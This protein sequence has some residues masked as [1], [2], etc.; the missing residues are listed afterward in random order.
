MMNNIWADIKNYESI[1][2]INKNGEIKSL[3]REFIDK[4]NRK[5]VIKEKILKPCKNT[6]GYLYVPLSKNGKVKN[7]NIHRLL[8]EHFISNPKNKPHINHIDGNKLNNS[9]DNLE[10]CTHKENAE[11]ASKL[12]L[13]KPSYSM[14]NKFGKDNPHSIKILQFDKEGTFIASF[15][16]ANEAKR[17]TGIDNSEILKVCKLK[18]K[19]AGGFIWKFANE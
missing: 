17:V 6:P 7:H 2:Q 12:K 14:K 8:A 5:Q 13:Y 11:H 3:A 18:R 4:T 15:Y 19:T 10:W 1:Y 9:L 16:G